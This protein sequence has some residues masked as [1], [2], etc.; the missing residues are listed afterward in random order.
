M[1]ST[2]GGKLFEDAPPLVLLQIEGDRPL[3]EVVVPEVEA[4][5]GVAAVFV[6]GSDAA[7]RSALRRLD[8]DHVGA[9][10]GK[11]LPQ[12]L[13]PVIGNLED[14]NVEQETLGLARLGQGRTSAALSCRAPILERPRPGVK[15]RAL[16]SS[17]LS[18][19]G[20]D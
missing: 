6:E 19:S 10:A 16:A 14:T 18:P 9:G 15:A 4:L 3:A 5:L 17:G 11:Q 7:G 20:E 8:L 12:E 13:A 1:T 2:P